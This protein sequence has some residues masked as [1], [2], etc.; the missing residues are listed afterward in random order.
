MKKQKLGALYLRV[1]TEEQ[2]SDM[3]QDEC[4]TYAVRENIPL[5]QKIIEKVTGAKQWRERQLADLLDPTA[6]L[7]DIIA[8]EYSRIGRDM[9]DTLDFI[10]QCN[11]KGITLHIAKTAN[12]I[13]ADMGGKILST[14]MTLAAEIERDHIRSRTRDALKN[15]KN[16]IAQNGFFITKAGEKITKLGR[17]EGESKNL[18]LAPH[19]EKI[20]ELRRANVS[21]AAIARIVECDVRTVRN[22][23]KRRESKT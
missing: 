8:Y 17:P 9:L 1:S 16:Q 10:R 19:A 20:T 3:Q 22:Y 7:T 21:L 4:A 5:V 13:R 14:V 15:R 18:K 6:G 12:V 11:E 23:I 2:N